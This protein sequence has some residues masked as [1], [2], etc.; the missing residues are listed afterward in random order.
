MDSRELRRALQDH[1]RR[2][3]SERSL[4]AVLTLFL[5]VVVGVGVAILLAVW[6]DIERAMMK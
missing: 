6:P 4:W 2:V 1:H 5:A 3:N